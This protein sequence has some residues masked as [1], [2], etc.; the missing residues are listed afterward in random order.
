MRVMMVV[1]G[2]SL[3]S[4]GVNCPRTPGSCLPES[5][6]VALPDGG[7]FTCFCVASDNGC[8]SGTCTASDGQSN[9]LC[10]GLNPNG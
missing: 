1:L 3:L 5:Q 2:L 4:C 8:C 10:S 6:Q 7:L 9:A